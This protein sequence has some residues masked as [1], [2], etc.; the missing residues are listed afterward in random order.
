MWTAVLFSSG[1]LARVHW[2]L[3]VGTIAMGAIGTLA[4]LFG[5]RTVSDRGT[6]VG[7]HVAVP[8]V[9]P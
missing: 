6:A 9:A 3:A 1:V 7:R 5:V 8:R 4:I 2:G